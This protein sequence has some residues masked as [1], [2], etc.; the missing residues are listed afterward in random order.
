MTLLDI[1]RKIEGVAAKQPSISMIVRNDVFRINEAPDLKYGIFAWLQGDHIQQE[2]SALVGYAFT[3]F[4]VDRLREDRKNELEVQSVG[5]TTLGNILQ[6]LRDD[7][8]EASGN[9]TYRTFNQRF[10]DECAGVFCTITLQAP[11]GS[12]CSESWAD[13]NEDFNDDFLIF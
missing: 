11:I 7:G 3:F 2:D 13:Y 5:I 12:V 8:I 1:I 9:I 4:Y 10:T 6:T